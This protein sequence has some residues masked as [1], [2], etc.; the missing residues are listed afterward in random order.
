M[1]ILNMK[2]KNASDA[3]YGIGM[4][5]AAV[6]FIQNSH[7]FLEGVIGLGKAVFWPAV[8]VYKVLELLKL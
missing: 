7:S 2:T 1:Y 3:I 4:I 8:V 5:G 6:Y